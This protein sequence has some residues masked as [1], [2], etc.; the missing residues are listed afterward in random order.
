MKKEQIQSLISRQHSFFATGETLSYRFRLSALQKLYQSIQEYE[1]GL[2]LALQTDLGKSGFES[3]TS[4]IGFVL[5]DIHYAIKHLKKWMKP[6][7]VATPLLMQPGKSRIYSVPLGVNLIISP[8]NYPVG[9][10][11]SPLIAAIAAGNTAVIKSA[12]TTPHVSKLID[13]LIKKTFEAEYIAHIEGDIEVNKILLE[14]KFDHIFFT[15]SSH[16]GRIV[17][18]QAAKSLTPVTLELGGKSPCIVHYDANLDIAARRI[19]YGKTLNAGQ[20]CIA[21]D[22]ALIHQ[23]V[24]DAFKQKL[25][26][27]IQEIFADDGLKNPDYGR[28]V[29]Q[30]HFDRLLSFIDADKVVVGGQHNRSTCFMAPTLLEGVDF[31]SKV[32]QEEIFGPVLPLIPYQSFD[33]IKA[34]MAKIPAYP[35]ALYWFGKDKRFSRKIIDSIRFGGGCINHTI[36]HLVNHELPFGGV[37]QSGMGAYHGKRGF[38]QFSHQKSIYQATTWFDL[39]LIYPPYKNKLKWVRRLFK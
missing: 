4:E 19:L 15:G 11:F 1:S 17:M 12:E 31:D 16:V 8:F 21:P 36:M 2:N 25:I 18:Q 10:T 34:V 23:S 30:Q 6:K 32:M 22:F 27:R 20:T 39:P 35:L 13:R 29:N 26:N 7:R 9:L 5:R 33:D 3:F 28:I 38:D 14:Q 24:Y 37:G